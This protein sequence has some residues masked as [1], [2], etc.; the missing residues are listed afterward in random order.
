MWLQKL[1]DM[2]VVAN[3]SFIQIIQIIQIIRLYESNRHIFCSI[4]KMN[5]LSGCKIF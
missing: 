5:F 2:H 4:F 1:F 3:E